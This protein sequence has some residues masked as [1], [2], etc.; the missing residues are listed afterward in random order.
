M[1]IVAFMVLNV[2]SV[3]GIVILNKYITDVDEYNF[4]VFLSFL[5]FVFTSIGTY[6]MLGLGFFNYQAAPLSG[7]LP[8]ALVYLLASNITLIT[9]L[10]NVMILFNIGELIVRSVYELE[11][12]KKFCRILSAFEA[13]LHPCHAHYPILCIQDVRPFYSATHACPHYLRSGLCHRL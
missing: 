13:R 4:M 11:F 6:V 5:H 10:F 9:I 1:A 2:V 3:V 8:V 12:G 7:V